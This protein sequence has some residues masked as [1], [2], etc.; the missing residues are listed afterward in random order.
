MDIKG[1]KRWLGDENGYTRTEKNLMLPFRLGMPCI[2][3]VCFAKHKPLAPIR[4]RPARTT[5]LCFHFN[6]NR[7]RRI[8]S[9]TQTVLDVGDHFLEAEHS[10]PATPHIR[11]HYYSA[12]TIAQTFT[13]QYITNNELWIANIHVFCVAVQIS[14]QVDFI[15]CN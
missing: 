5:F 6:H 12:S 11:T 13:I 9:Y 4:A 15:W 14:K 7:I 1:G 10:W 2:L 3:L 8:H